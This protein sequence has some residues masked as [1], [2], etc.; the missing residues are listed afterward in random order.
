MANKGLVSLPMALNIKDV[1][2]A[3]ISTAAIMRQ[4]AMRVISKTAAPIKIAKVEVS[5]IEPWIPPKKVCI[6][7]MPLS[8]AAAV[9]PTE[10]S[11]APSAAKD[12]GVAP[13]KL[14]TAVH[15]E[16]PEICAG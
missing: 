10:K 11:I 5:P 4:E 13:L 2:T 3:P 1:S 15:T 7:V 16:S 12:K 6:H 8:V 14:S 9:N